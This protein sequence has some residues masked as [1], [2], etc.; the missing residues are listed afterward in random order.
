MTISTPCSYYLHFPFAVM[1]RIGDDTRV[2]ECAPI[3][4]YLGINYHIEYD[5]LF[6]AFTDGRS[7]VLFVRSKEVIRTHTE[8]YL[9]QSHRYTYASRVSLSTRSSLLPNTRSARLTCTLVR[10]RKVEP[11]FRIKNTS[12]HVHVRAYVHTCTSVRFSGKC[13]HVCGTNA[14]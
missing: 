11:N 7:A 4:F 10:N 2:R 13:S 1:S 9:R 5:F 8:S 6:Q 12:R 3:F 14:A